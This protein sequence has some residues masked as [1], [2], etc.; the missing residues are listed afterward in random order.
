MI[1]SICFYESSLQDQI[2]LQ[3]PYFNFFKQIIYCLL[4][5]LQEFQFQLSTCI[6]IFVYA[7]CILNRFNPYEDD[8][9][10][11]QK[12]VYALDFEPI[13]YLIL[14]SNNIQ[15]R[16]MTSFSAQIA[17]QISFTLTK[18]H[19]STF[20]LIIISTQVCFNIC[21]IHILI[22][23]Y[24]IVRYY[25]K[26]IVNDISFCIDSQQTQFIEISSL[27]YFEVAIPLMRFYKVLC[28]KFSK[29]IFYPYYGHFDSLILPLF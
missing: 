1:S 2:F 9:Q 3:V 14:S 23:F 19:H 4:K 27:H 5:T 28:R 21:R 22:I 13:G 11:F 20:Y 29:S 26:D 25:I 8:K 12:L 10:V 24:N 7:S 16:C 17:S 6:T 15:I 18:M